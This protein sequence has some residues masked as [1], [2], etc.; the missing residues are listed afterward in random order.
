MGLTL[1][2][3]LMVWSLVFSDFGVL[4]D[5]PHVFNVFPV[6]FSITSHFISYVLPKAKCS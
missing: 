1:G 4:N 3:K 6:M 2:K 5:V